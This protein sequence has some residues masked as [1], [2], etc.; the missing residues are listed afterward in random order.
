[1]G[2]SVVAL[3]LFGEGADAAAG[4]TL[5]SEDGGFA[6]LRGKRFA[7]VEACQSE[8]PAGRDAARLSLA[9]AAGGAVRWGLYRTSSVAKAR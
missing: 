2:S 5:A 9:S 7:V 6:D 8:L 3:T 1:M 4:L